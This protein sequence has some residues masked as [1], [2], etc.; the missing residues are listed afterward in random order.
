MSHEISKRHVSIAHLR[1]R[2]LSCADEAIA[3]AKAEAEELREQLQEAEMEGPGGLVGGG[4]AGGG[5]GWWG[6]VVGGAWGFHRGH[7]K[8]GGL[9]ESYFGTVGTRV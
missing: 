5:G 8:P 4:G 2:K 9:Q 3:R 6:W 7:Q 1:R